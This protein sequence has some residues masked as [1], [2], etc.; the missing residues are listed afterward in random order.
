MTTASI[1]ASDNGVDA[2]HRHAHEHAA[3]GLGGSEEHHGVLA[4]AAVSG[5]VAID[6]GPG[7]GALV[8]Y[9]SDRFRGRE[10]E[11]S[12]VGT[13]PGC[14]L[15]E[16]LE[17]DL[18]A[19]RNLPVCGDPYS[20]R[21]RFPHSSARPHVV[22]PVQV[23]PQ[24]DDS[25]GPGRGTQ[26]TVAHRLQRRG[27]LRIDRA[28]GSRLVPRGLHP[29]EDHPRETVASTDSSARGVPSERAPAGGGRFRGGRQ[30]RVEHG[31]RSATARSGGTGAT[32]I[33]DLSRVSV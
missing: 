27:A 14:A 13:A 31:A 3:H 9:P 22:F 21:T 16:Q 25:P 26:E 20:S 15:L 30:G 10:I 11:I 4:P 19:R 28:A 8:L 33:S 23:R 32:G 12:R 18:A 7:R 1:I 6:V 24:P 17:P 2:T 5:S 29:M